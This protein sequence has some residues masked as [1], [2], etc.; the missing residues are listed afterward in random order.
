[1]THYFRFRY[2]YI[3][4]FRAVKVKVSVAK[5]KKHEA[6]IYSYCLELPDDITPEECRLEILGKEKIL[7]KLRK[8]TESSWDGYKDEMVASTESD[9]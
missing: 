3:Y 9:P 1:M 2:I 6:I 8:L 7:L 4:N 5:N